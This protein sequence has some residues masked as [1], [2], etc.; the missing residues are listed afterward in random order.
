MTIWLSGP[1]L[2]TVFKST[3][4]QIDQYPDGKAFVDSLDEHSYDLVFLDLMMPEMNG[5]QVL[6]ELRSR[7]IEVPVIIFS[8]LTKKEDRNESP[9]IRCAHLLEKTAQAGK[10]VTQSC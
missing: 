5:F 6:Q 3:G 2:S 9:G 10:A 4:W 8:A 1:L 7:K